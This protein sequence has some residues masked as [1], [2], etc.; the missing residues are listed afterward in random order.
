VYVHC[1]LW[2]I[3]LEFGTTVSEEEGF[4]QGGGAKVSRPITEQAPITRPY[5]NAECRASGVEDHAVA[6]L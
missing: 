1:A 3:L 6:A 4:K 2:A 5:K